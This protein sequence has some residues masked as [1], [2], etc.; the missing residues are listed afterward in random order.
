MS[1]AS[2][3]LMASAGIL[4]SALG[5]MVVGTFTSGIYKTDSSKVGYPVE[6][7][8]EGGGGGGAKVE[9]LPD[10]GTLLADPAKLA[11]LVA[12]GEKLSKTCAACHDLTSAATNK[13]GPAL[14]NVLGRKAGSHGGFAYS[15]SMK[16]FAQTWTYDEIDAFVKAPKEL[17]KDTKM[18]FAGM[19]KQADRIAIVAYLKS[20]SPSAPALPAPDPTRDP[21]KVAEA[22]AA[23]SGTADANAVTATNA[24]EATNAVAPI[25]APAH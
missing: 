13:T 6:V 4:A 8:E 15:D 7:S 25:T 1:K 10:W 19:P 11:E 17:V 16:T 24:V 20:I 14:W 2:F 3:G 18:S 22:A 21:A 23:A 12:Q 5:I 9:L